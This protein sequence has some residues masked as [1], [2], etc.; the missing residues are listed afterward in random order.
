[1]QALCDMRCVP[2]RGDV[3]T[4]TEAEKQAFLSQ[5][6]RW[7]ILA[8][9]GVDK[10][11]K[12]LSLSVDRGNQYKQQLVNH[13]LAIPARVKVGRTYRVVLRPTNDA[14]RLCPADKTPAGRASFIHEYWKQFYAS[15]YTDQGYSVRLE[16]PRRQGRTDILARRA[17]E[18]VAIEI[19]TG[20]SD[21]VHNVRQN[22]LQRYSR[23][24]VVATDE[25]AYRQIERQLSRARLI[26]PSR[27]KLVLRDDLDA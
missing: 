11:Y 14:Q 18:S 4:V 17:S 1:M 6:P 19:E 5:V 21:A 8:D 22:L 3:P 16:V 13:G 24:I 2:C 27:I 23:V 25:A 9:D 12:R 10:R 20:K 7:T 26:L 15:Q